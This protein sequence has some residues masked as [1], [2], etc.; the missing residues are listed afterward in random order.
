MLD[1]FKRTLIDAYVDCE[2]E[3]LDFASVNVTY[4]ELRFMRRYTEIEEYACELIRRNKRRIIEKNHAE[5]KQTD[6]LI[7]NDHFEMHELAYD[8][9]LQFE[10]L[11]H[12]L[13]N[14]I[15]EIE[16]RD[17]QKLNFETINITLHHRE[18]LF[19]NRFHTIE[20]YTDRRRIRH[21]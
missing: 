4:N 6:E 12:T 3:K 10:R 5:N 2:K 8:G 19:I 1:E 20:E 17:V 16:Q 14:A 18:F 13:Q 15:E 11:L 9:A 7:W 21:R